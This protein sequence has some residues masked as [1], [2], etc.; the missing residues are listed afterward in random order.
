[1]GLS[2]IDEIC[3]QLI[4]DGTPANTSAAIIFGAGSFSE[5]I[6]KGTVV[7]LP[8]LC[9]DFKTN[10]PGIIVIGA[11]TNFSYQSNGA[12]GGKRILVTCSDALQKTALKVIHEM[13]GIPIPYPA[14]KLTPCAD[15][16]KDLATG[17][18]FDWL[19]LTSPSAVHSMVSTLLP[20]NIDIRSLPPI[21]VS[22]EGTAKALR[23]YY[24]KAA[25]VPDKNFSAEG[26]L[27]CTA[28]VFKKGQRILRLRSDRAGDSL[29]RELV[30]S[31]LFVTDRVICINEPVHSGPVP[32]FD[33][34]F[35]ASSSAVAS[36]LD[37][38]DPIEISGKTVLAIGSP[39]SQALVKRG[40]SDIISGPEALTESTIKTYAIQT[41]RKLIDCAIKKG[42][43]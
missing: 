11:V 23:E 5:H 28:K 27:Q 42:I 25:I 13:G 30:K 18:Q 12:L 8:V 22:G 36:L 38:N 7:S 26:L 19:I 31:G 17:E 14:I 40:I 33:T 15:G 1:M 43:S 32:D 41:I 2:S 24:L 10:Q 4:T 39:T 35:F 6:I 16:L 9:K 29:S 20:A 34:I 3:N 37:R 21:V